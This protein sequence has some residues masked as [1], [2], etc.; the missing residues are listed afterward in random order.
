MRAIFLYSS[1]VSSFQQRTLVTPM[2]YTCTF[3]KAREKN[4]MTTGQN[5]KIAPQ[6]IDLKHKY[7]R[8]T[9]TQKMNILQRQ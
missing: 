2:N 8:D 4:P 5:R 3:R 7:L 9:H 6:N 1:V